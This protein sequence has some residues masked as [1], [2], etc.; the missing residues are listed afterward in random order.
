M[1]KVANVEILARALGRISP[2]EPKTYEALAV[3][4]LLAPMQAEPEWVTT[5]EAG[6]RAR[7]TAVGEATYEPDLRAANLGDLPLA[8]LDGEL[9]D[10][11]QSRILNTTVLVPP[12]SEL[13]IPTCH[14]EQGRWRYYDRQFA[15]G[16]DGFDFACIN[17]IPR[18]IRVTPP[19]HIRYESE[20]APAREAL[21][22]FPGQVGAVAYVAGLWAGL[23]LLA[24]PGLFA[25]AWWHLCVGYAGE[26]YWR[27]PAMPGAPSPSRILGMLSK[28]PVES[29]PAVGLGVEHRWSG[30]RLA[31]AALVAEGRVAH[32]MAFPI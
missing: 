8:L 10:A 18:V 28:C 26:A 29:A 30:T 17:R 3:I 27:T 1:P 7:I 6:D 4:P 12:R 2:G 19:F 22:P 9:V 23:E 15:P 20:L 5:A 11:K 14:M 21:A 13:I 16:R 31:G 24:A 25:R 32:L